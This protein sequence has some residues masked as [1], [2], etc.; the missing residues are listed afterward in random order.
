MTTEIDICNK[1]IL[2][3]GGNMVSSTTGLVA[4]LVPDSLEAKLCLL[5]YA[6]IRDIVTEDRVWSF[7]ISRVVLSVPSVTP[8]PF[9]FTHGFPIPADSL[10]IWRVSY[11]YNTSLPAFP[12]SEPVMNDWRV[13]DNQILANSS[14]IYVE[15]VRRL[16]LVGDI[17]LFSPQFIDVLSLRLAV[18]F[19]IPLCENQGLFNA[20]A[21][22]Y[23]K[24][25][26]EAYAVNG[27]QA[28]HEQFRSTQLLRVR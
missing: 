26:V 2:R 7:A 8:P 17:N 16:D 9:G 5:N 15:Y 6:L 22:E 21:G 20:L 24:R 12:N 11:E 23:K 13:E 10:N 18:E 3:L 14:K 25:L 28:K 1:A 27:S 19:C 4:D